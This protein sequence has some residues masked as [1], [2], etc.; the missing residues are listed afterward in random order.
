MREICSAHGGL[1]NLSDE[2]ART[3]LRALSLVSTVLDEAE[4]VRWPDGD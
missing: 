4:H 2:D 1:E 3:V